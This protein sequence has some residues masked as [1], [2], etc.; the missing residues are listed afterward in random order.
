MFAEILF[1]LQESKGVELV[2]DLGKQHT[3]L[4]REEGM[5]RGRCQVK[6][7]KNRRPRNKEGWK[8]LFSCREEKMA[9]K[10]NRS[11]IL[12]WFQSAYLLH[13]TQTTKRGDPW[14]EYQLPW[15]DTEETCQHQKTSIY[16]PGLDPAPEPGCAELSLC[17]MFLYLGEIDPSTLT[18]FSRSWTLAHK[19]LRNPQV[20]STRFANYK[21]D[22][23]SVN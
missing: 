14:G 6:K 11:H 23:H 8:K 1:P 3:I 16:P 7:K 13:L 21:V 15:T 18:E 5:V 10:E 12:M 17:I 19:N 22:S 9:S 4:C 2:L 20:Q